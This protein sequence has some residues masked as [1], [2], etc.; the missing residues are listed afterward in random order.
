LTI[1]LQSEVE[2]LAGARRS[3]ALA[4]FDV[5]DEWIQRRDFNC[6]S[7]IHSLVDEDGDGAVRGWS[8]G[9]GPTWSTLEAYAEQAGSANPREAGR[10]LQ[11]LMMGAIVSA[12]CGDGQAAK[13]ARSLAERV[14]DG[15]PQ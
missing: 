8:S 15:S 3:R 10:Q 6:S 2:R 14:L 9:V 1:W 13:R 5:L 4:V 12:G 7:T 11:I